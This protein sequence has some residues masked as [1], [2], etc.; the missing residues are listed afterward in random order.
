MCDCRIAC[1]LNDVDPADKADWPKQHEWLVK[2]LNELHRIF[3]PRVRAFD[4]D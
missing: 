1:Y 3:A 4:A 2:R